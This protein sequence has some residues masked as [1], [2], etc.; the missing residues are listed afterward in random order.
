MAGDKLLKGFLDLMKEKK[1]ILR[2][3]A[4]AEGVHRLRGVESGPEIAAEEKGKKEG[5]LAKGILNGRPFLRE[6]IEVSTLVFR[7][8]NRALMD[9]DEQ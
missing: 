9:Q 1:W 6:A 3:K 4:G 5:K 7:E 8:V 2:L